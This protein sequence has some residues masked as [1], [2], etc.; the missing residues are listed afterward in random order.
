MWFLDANLGDAVAGLP[1]LVDGA[2][3]E[4]SLVTRHMAHL[5]S[6]DTD[7]AR[8]AASLAWL[9]EQPTVWERQAVRSLANFAHTDSQLAE[10]IVGLPWFKDDI[11]SGEDHTL[12]GLTRVSSTDLELAKRIMSSSWFVDD[13]SW[14]EASALNALGNAALLGNPDLA[15]W[16][17]YAVNGGVGLYAISTISRVM[18]MGDD[19]WDRLT[20]QPWFADGL[21]QE[22]LAL[23][24]VLGSH[25]PQ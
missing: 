17:E 13:I 4:E 3:F 5:A 21:D 23:I 14:A 19:S 7:I 9:A 1:W 22:E 16:G 20:E 12:R 2:T 11:T 25:R 18:D 10:S 15:Q 6:A 24:Y 8:M